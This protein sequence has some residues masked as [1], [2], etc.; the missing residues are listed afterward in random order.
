MAHVR[1]F[2]VVWRS[3]AMSTSA[4]LK[5]VKVMLTLSRPSSTLT[6]TIHR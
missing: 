6:S 4:T 5:I 1:T 2:W 3:F